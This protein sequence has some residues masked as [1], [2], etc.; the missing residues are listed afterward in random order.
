MKMTM[1][2]NILSQKKCKKIMMA[3]NDAGMLFYASITKPDSLMDLVA[4][5]FAYYQQSEVLAEEHR[6][7][8]EECC[9][10]NKQ[11]LKSIV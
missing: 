10:R 8:V 7:K 11:L 1:R 9:L 6:V 5:V 3:G 4:R 2:K